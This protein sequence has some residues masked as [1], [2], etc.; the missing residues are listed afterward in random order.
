MPCPPPGVFPI[1]R[2]KPRLLRLLHWQ[3][4]SLPLVPPGKP[5]AAYLEPILNVE[6]LTFSEIA[7]PTGNCLLSA[8]LTTGGVL[9]LF[10]LLLMYGA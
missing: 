2:S 3:A 9:P 5:P 1:Q 7:Y 10:S 6:K 8:K 4:G